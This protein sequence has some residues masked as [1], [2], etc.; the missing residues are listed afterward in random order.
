M[1]GL[2]NEWI[3][4]NPL[5]INLLTIDRPLI[6]LFSPPGLVTVLSRKHRPTTCVGAGPIQLIYGSRSTFVADLIL[7]NFKLHH[8][9]HGLF[10]YRHTHT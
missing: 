10:L 2:I 9:F 7:E 4:I 3:I 6:R 5:I 8:F 1:N